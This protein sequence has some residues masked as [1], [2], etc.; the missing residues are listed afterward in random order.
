MTISVLV[1]DDS[2]FMRKVIPDIL[3]SDPD[4][5]VIGTAKD[6]GDALRKIPNLNPDV[7]T[8]DIQMPEMDGLTTLRKIMESFPRPVVMISSQEAEDSNVTIEAL[9]SGA[10]DFILKPSGQISLDMDKVSLELI[11]KIKAAA[12]AKLRK[13]APKKAMHQSFAGAVKKLIAIG[14]STGGPQTLEQII[15]AL[16]GNIPACILVVQ[17]MPPFFTKSLAERLDKI[18]ELKVMEAKD[19]DEIK[20]GIVYI[21]PGDYHMELKRTQ[22]NGIAKE[23]ISLN[24]RDKELGVRPNVNVMMRS[25]APVYKQNTVA[26]ILTGMG[27]DGTEGAMAI[28]NNGGTVLVQDEQSS[29]I[30]GMPKSVVESGYY[31]EIVELSKIPVALL[32]VL[33]L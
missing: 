1:V 23:T 30:Y 10:V 5:K 9:E 16:P 29:I 12:L 26:V 8:L 20:E 3:N 4:I 21:A 33:E 18:S 27:S 2:A 24:K 19:N 32:Q 22:E 6:G 14:S 11:S 31:D 7:V 28:K 13:Y 17:H 15:P 25:I